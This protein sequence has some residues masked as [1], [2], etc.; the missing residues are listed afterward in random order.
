MI[1]VHVLAVSILGPATVAEAASETR[2][3]F[4]L[5][6]DCG[7]TFAPGDDVPFLVSLV[8]RASRSQT[9]D[10]TVTVTA[11]GLGTMEVLSTTVTLSPR[12]A[13]SIERDL[14]LPINAPAGDYALDVVA[15]GGK[16]TFSAG[17]AFVVESYR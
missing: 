14:G 15:V 5:D 11:P 3:P 12:R 13:S 10:V 17:C 7:G 4:D 16:A 1:W 2:Q 8:E 6:L 9:L